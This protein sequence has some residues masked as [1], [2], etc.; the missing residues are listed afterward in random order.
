MINYHVFSWRCKLQRP[1][2]LYCYDNTFIHYPFGETHCLWRDTVSAVDVSVNEAPATH[3]PP[4]TTKVLAT[5]FGTKRQFTNTKLTSNQHIKSQQQ[6]RNSQR[7]ER[8]LLPWKIK[9]HSQLVSPRPHEFS[10][11]SM[12]IFFIIGIPLLFWFQ[13]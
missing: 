3:A 13:S 9:R 4:T 10:E 12:H 5:A 6:R 2:W 11:K 1:C 7:Q 8:Q